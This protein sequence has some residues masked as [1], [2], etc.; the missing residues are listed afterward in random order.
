MTVGQMTLIKSSSSLKPE[1]TNENCDLMEVD[2][3]DEKHSRKV[4]GRKRT[5]EELMSKRTF[6]AVQELWVTKNNLKLAL[7][8][9]DR[10]D[11][12]RGEYIS[13]IDG[14]KCGLNAKPCVVKHRLVLVD[15]APTSRVCI[16]SKE[17]NVY[18][19]IRRIRAALY[20]EV[21]LGIAL[22]PSV[23]HKN[24]YERSSNM[25]AIKRLVVEAVKG[26]YSPGNNGRINQ[27]DPLIELST[28]Q[29]LMTPNGHE[30]IAKMHELLTDG[31]NMYKIEEYGGDE[32]FSVL[33]DSGKYKDCR[34]N[35]DEAKRYF[36]QILN[37]IEYMHKKGVCH[38]DLSLENVLVDDS[39]IKLIDFGLARKIPVN[40]ETG[41]YEKFAAGS[42]LPTNKT[43][44]LAPEIFR[45]EAFD[46]EK[47]DI[48]SA[49]TMLFIML[50]GVPA[51]EK[52]VAG[53][54]NFEAVKSGRVL[55]LMK[56][57][58]L[59]DLVTPT[60]RDLIKKLFIVDIDKRMTIEEIRSHPWFSSN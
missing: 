5:R 25:V 42:M 43:F 41:E 53:D 28:L 15:G 4:S 38:L 37:G 55:E 54:A 6:E 33:C 49:A 23:S 58:N 24:V 59:Y 10:L 3:M 22:K 45:M 17:G 16:I 60:A 40:A 36:L 34:F 32:M 20:G 47:A 1:S 11:F 21:I 51:F 39:K 50:T 48:W 29:Y 13:A 35:E 12:M 57:W 31:K 8:E 56:L 7:K 46:G 30:N 26:R 52:P 44:Y 2:V 19:L 14:S 9:S 18:E 27:E